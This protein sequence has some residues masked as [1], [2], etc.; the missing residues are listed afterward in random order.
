MDR[1]SIIK[2]PASLACWL[3][4]PLLRYT[5]KPLSAGV[6]PPAS[7]V[8]GHHL[9]AAEVF[10]KSERNVRWQVHHLHPRRRRT[11]APFGVVDGVQNGTVEMATPRLIT[12]SARTNLRPGLR[13][14]VRPNSRQMTAWM[15]E[16]NGLKLMREFYAST[17]S[18]TSR[19][20]HGRP[21]G[22]LVP[23]R[24]SSRWPT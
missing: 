8:A 24:K 16:G 1:R 9:G 6:W 19:R 14:S 2:M 15:Y 18:S 20:Q 3:L 7:Q 22:R 10:A 12:S 4:V 11:D 17:A 5:H 13:H 23:Q 21:D